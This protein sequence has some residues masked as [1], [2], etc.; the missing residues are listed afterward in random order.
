MR[1]YDMRIIVIHLN[2]AIHYEFY[3]LLTGQITLLLHSLFLLYTDDLKI[4]QVRH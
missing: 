3:Q 1:Y 4:I 2:H